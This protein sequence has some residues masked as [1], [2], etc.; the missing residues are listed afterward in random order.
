[1]SCI[2]FVAFSSSCPCRSL[3][4]PCLLFCLEKNPGWKWVKRITENR[5]EIVTWLVQQS[6]TSIP[7]SEL[8]FIF[9][10]SNIHYA[11]T[12]NWSD[13][14]RLYTLTPSLENYMLGAR[15]V[16]VYN[17]QSCPCFFLLL[18]WTLLHYSA[19][20]AHPETNK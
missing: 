5:W 19:S 4:A 11:Q 14:Y 13:F 9:A 20:Y 7:R 12:R 1:M 8:V 18:S 2:S 10:L 3:A 6:L 17:S 16:Y 15:G